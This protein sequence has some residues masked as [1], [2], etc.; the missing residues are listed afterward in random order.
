MYDPDRVI[1]ADWT[2]AA[3]YDATCRLW[4]QERN[5]TAIFA[6]SDLIAVGVLSA[7]GRRG[8]R[9]PERDAGVRQAGGHGVAEPVGAVEVDQGARAVTHVQP[10]GQIGQQIPQGVAGVGPVAVAVHLRRKE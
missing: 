1:E 5:V 3:G 6:H 2:A 4:A 7:L 10:D 8:V 9:V